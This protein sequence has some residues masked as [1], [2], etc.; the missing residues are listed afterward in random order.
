[1]FLVDE[2]G[3]VKGIVTLTDVVNELLGPMH[4][5]ADSRVVSKDGKAMVVRAEMP[6]THVADYMKKPGWGDGADVRS[7]GGLMVSRIG[8][9]PRAGESVNID[10]V[11]L[12]ADRVTSRSVE[13]VRI[14]DETLPVDKIKPPAIE[15]A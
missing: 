7:V 12:T 6:I 2:H 10:G 11:R 8:R 9:V 1:M 4:E 15:K 13:L 3:S 5:G 14:E